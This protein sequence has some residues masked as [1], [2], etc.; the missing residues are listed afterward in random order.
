MEKVGR[1]GRRGCLLRRREGSWDPR[2]EGTPSELMENAKK[3]ESGRD[4]ME[5]RSEILTFVSRSKSSS[6]EGGLASLRED[7]SVEDVRENRKARG[8]VKK[9]SRRVRNSQPD[10]TSSSEGRRAD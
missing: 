7:G 8:A 5:T 10:A 9:S 1:R 2:V 3:S 6:R 4:S